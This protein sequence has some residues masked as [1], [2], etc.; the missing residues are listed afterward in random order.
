MG[1]LSYTKDYSN[2]QIPLQ[3]VCLLIDGPQQP[4]LQTYYKITNLNALNGW[5]SPYDFP[6]HG[7]KDPYVGCIVPFHP[8][9]KD[10]PKLEP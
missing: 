6:T 10:F 2:Y 9:T 5:A 3:Y 8:S 1:T 7:V 4:L